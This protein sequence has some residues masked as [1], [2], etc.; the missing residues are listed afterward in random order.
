M[1]LL[2]AIWRIALRNG[3]GIDLTMN[4]DMIVIPSGVRL[5]VVVLSLDEGRPLSALDHHLS[6]LPDLGGGWNLQEVHFMF[7]FLL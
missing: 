1:G 5:V 7:N 3:L 6:V 2:R 4:P